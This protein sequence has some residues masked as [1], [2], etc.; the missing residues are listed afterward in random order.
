MSKIW[1]YLDVPNHQAISDEVYDYVVNYTDAL[2]L[3]EN[4]IDPEPIRRMLS[5]CPL[6]AEFL[7]SQQLTP[8]ILGIIVID[9]QSGLGI[10][11]DSEDLKS[12][13]RVTW[14][15]KNCQGSMTKIWKITEGYGE[16]NSDINGK[17]YTK[18][19]SKQQAEFELIDEFELRS[20]VLLDVSYPHSVHPNTNSPGHRISFTIGFDR[21]LPVSKSIKSWFG[22]QR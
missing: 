19:S 14:P 11:T 3:V 12:Y 13:I 1:K 16:V 4:Y 20:P 5:H 18:F 21:D 2:E 22:F 17:L 15:V 9:A 10:H 8:E 7:H 6:L